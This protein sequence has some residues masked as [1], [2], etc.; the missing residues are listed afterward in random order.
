MRS[1]VLKRSRK[2]AFI[3]CVSLTRIK[4]M[5]LSGSLGSAVFTTPTSRRRQ[6]AQ[7]RPY[8]GD[9][10]R[11]RR[12]RPAGP[13]ERRRHLLERFVNQDPSLNETKYWNTKR[14]ADYLGVSPDTFNCMRLIG[15]FVP[16]LCQTGRPGS[17]TIHPILTPGSRST[18]AVLPTK[19]SHRDVLS[20][21]GAASF[22]LF[23]CVSE[24]MTG[25]ACRGNM[26][27]S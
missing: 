17:S 11:I 9:R 13:E 5:S 10:E 20:T 3:F 22:G 18:S 25:V 12:E 15:D 23:A 2:T 21:I 27:T 1:V 26:W 14:A 4:T 6:A 19:K 16:P 8:P 7:A 24:F